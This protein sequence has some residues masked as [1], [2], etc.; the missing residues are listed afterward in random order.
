MF[1][2]AGR[3]YDMAITQFSPEGRLFQVEYAIEAVRRGTTAIVCRNNNSVVFAVEKKSAELQEVIGSE[4]IF[5]VDEH[6]G[7]AIAGLTA[8]AR[9]LVDRARVQAQVNILNYDEK[10]SVKDSTLNIC[11]YLQLF[12]Q[13]A[14]VRPFGVSFLIAGVDTNGEASLYLTDPSGA[15]WGYKA[16]AIGSGTTEARTYLEEHYKEDISD[17]ELKLLPLRTLKELMGDNLNKD[18]CDVAFIMKDDVK[19]KLLNDQEKEDLLSK[20]L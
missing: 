13:N 19:F 4:K 20:L 16:W 3:G 11:E 17:E 12:T 5:K 2:Q 10:I 7:V 14:G 8:D 15:M 1:Q 6:I 9:V 18:T